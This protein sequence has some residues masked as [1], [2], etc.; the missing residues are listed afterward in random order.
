LEQLLPDIMIQG[1]DLPNSDQQPRSSSSAKI[2]DPDRSRTT[3]VHF[4]VLNA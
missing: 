3:D 2:V 1:N 4:S